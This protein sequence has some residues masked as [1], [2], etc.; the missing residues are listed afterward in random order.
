[1]KPVRLQ[2]VSLLF[3]AALASTPLGAQQIIPFVGGGVALGMG[4][5]GEDS[6]A[7]WLVLGGFDVPLPIVTDGFGIG[8]SASYA[9]VPYEGGFSEAMQVTT[10]SGEITY[11][12]GEAAAMVRPYLRGGAGV[13]IHRYEPG[14]T[15]FSPVTDTRAGVTAGAGVLV[16]MGAADAM[17]GARFNSGTDGGYLGVHVG[18]AIPVGP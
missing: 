3:G 7:G 4:D 12:I 2:F 10:V 1:M 16:M 5:V 9:N 13:Q 8:V 17:L 18:V 6:S 14:D 15:N 11:R